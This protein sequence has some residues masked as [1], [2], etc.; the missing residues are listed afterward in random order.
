MAEIKVLKG[1][2]YTPDMFLKRMAKS[3]KLKDT[4]TVRYVTACA[5]SFSFASHCRLHVKQ[6]G[7]QGIT[8]D[9]MRSP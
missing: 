8:Q 2:R 4:I 3:K 5:G 7:T 6:P 1:L 9:L